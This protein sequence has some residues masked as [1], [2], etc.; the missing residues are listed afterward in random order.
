MHR[1]LLW[2]TCG[3]VAPVI[4]GA[5]SPASTATS[6]PP[7]VDREIARLQEQLRATG[8]DVSSTCRLA[9][10]YLQKARET[11]DPTYYSKSDTLLARATVL[12]PEHLETLCLRA[13][14]ALARHRFHD[15]L[16]IGRRARELYPRSAPACGVVGDAQI[17]L[18]MY[19]DAVRTIQAMVDLRPDLSSYSRVAYIREL[20][21]DV[22]GALDAMTRALEAGGV[23][24]ENVAWCAVQRGTLR[25]GSGDLD[26]A[27]ADYDRAIQLLPH[28]AP[29]L[30]GRARVA[31][32]RGHIDDAVRLYRDANALQPLPENI[33]ALGDLL[34]ATGR[35]A[36]ARR[37][38]ALV[39]AIERLQAENGV[40]TDIEMALFDA[41]HLGA[42]GAAAETLV[43]RARTARERR[44]SIKSDE[45]L[46][47]TL[48]R[49]GHVMEAREVMSR[50]LR[51]HT[52]DALMYYHSGM[53]AAAAGDTTAAREQLTQALALNPAFSP[54]GAREA[55][56][57]LARLA[58]GARDTTRGN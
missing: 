25:F 32:A 8:G 16:A 45:T 23:V 21:G 41:D 55:R 44:P 3:L 12:Q 46:A 40:D 53:I 37:E 7:A 26:G 33:I 10:L 47:W 31:A 28:Y 2:I 49:T 17:E 30:G 18:G 38:Y 6:R 29:A 24:P 19:E 5:G 9:A 56:A 27:G 39:R 34:A 42:E 22:A 4:A 1:T 13:T 20:H 14:L 15:A 35:V 43:T 54:L 52:R 50:A 57:A 48:Y 51:L 36:E 58:A 11:G